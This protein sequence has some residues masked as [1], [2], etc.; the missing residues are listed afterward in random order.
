M[1]CWRV[2]E[3]DPSTSIGVPQLLI[4]ADFGEHGYILWL[5]DLSN[6]WSEDLS[7]VG[8]MERA[9]EV[10]SPIE[11]GRQDTTQ[12]G[13]L[14][15]HLQNSL[16]NAEG[17][18]CR[19]T[20]YNE[21]GVILNTVIDLPEPL[22][23]LKWKFCLRKQSPTMLKNELILP[24]LLS[25]HIQ[26]TR[27][28]KLT[29]I[30]AE[31]DKAMSRLLDQYASNHLDLAS[32]FPS[33]SGSKGNRRI[34]KREQVSRYIPALRPFVQD[35]WMEETTRHLYPELCTLDLFQEALSEC[36]PS[37]PSSMKS[38]ED[39]GIWWEN[40]KATMDMSPPRP[41]STTRLDPV[42]ES[43]PS[44]EGEDTE[45]EDEFETHENFKSRI[46]ERRDNSA[47]DNR[48]N[49]DPTSKN[50]S[51]SQSRLQH[52]MKLESQDHVLPTRRRSSLSVEQPALATSLP[53]VP[54]DHSKHPI[55]E[56]TTS[57]PKPKGF[58]IGGAKRSPA[59]VEAKIT[60][61]ENVLEDNMNV[62]ITTASQHNEGRRRKGFKIGG[63]DK[64][65]SEKET[66]NE[67]AGH[68][69]ES[70]RLTEI[71]DVEPT[72]GA[73][74]VETKD[75]HEEEVK[76]DETAEEKAER[77]RSELKRKNDDLSR[78]QAQRKKKRF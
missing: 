73:S 31:K 3:L 11:V 54:S 28:K 71:P 45:T 52:R 6:I 10:E 51:Q 44:S 26:Y 22:D 47:D 14:L 1:A 17:T 40:I 20:K 41:T 37:V 5:T 57:R 62:Q 55:A 34:A 60:S 23:S 58:K 53:A 8:I 15:E 29:T 21:S 76:H 12:Q 30:I 64:R 69:E 38:R 75:T 50:D 43:R 72:R 7:V 9:V 78:R 66:K 63:K 77:K 65:T 46:P 68:I 27:V 2:L 33:V 48:D 19:L 49:S 36:N 70:S 39:E 16:T 13:I 25:G 32:V 74:Q 42:I 24:L 4:K 61:E 67:F 56:P 18:V 59:T 35:E